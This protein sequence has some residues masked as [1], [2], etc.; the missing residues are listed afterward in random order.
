MFRRL[1][2]YR[3]AMLQLAG[4]A[5]VTLLMPAARAQAALPATSSGPD[6]P[7]S[8]NQP[9]RVAGQ[10]EGDWRMRALSFALLA[11]NPHNLQPWIVDLRQA[12]QVS[13]HY[14]TSRALPMTDP[15]GRQ[16]LIGC[17]CFLELLDMAAREL[18]IKVDTRYFPQ[19]TPSADKLD[20]KPLATLRR[21][22]GTAVADPLFAH[23]LRRRSTKAAYDMTREVS[24]EARATM[25]Q[26]VAGTSRANGLSLSVLRG[27]DDKEKLDAL[28]D[29]IWQAWLIEASTPRTHKESVDLMRIGSA[30]VMANPDGISL[31]S[32]MF[33]RMK[34]AGQISREAMLDPNSPGNRMGQQRYAAM[35]KATP[36]M[37]W[38]TSAD[39]SRQT[40]LDSG[41]A[42]M[43]AA[44]AATGLGLSVH[45][46]SQALQ[47]YPEM[48]SQR[49]Q[50]HRLLQAAEP[51]RVQM[52]CRLGYGP[53]VEPSPRR[54]LQALLRST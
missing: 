41:R 51:S 45:P 32:P 2:V 46:V 34:A 1:T 12:D 13:L 8:A 42:Y 16:L 22:A 54:P 30:E 10:V 43:R 15:V 52:L 36:A 14:D 7:L 28:R 31:G 3:R 35:M 17:G 4:G 40:Q 11:P 20:S 38:L 39:N 37:L 23:V 47:E 26:A 48:A 6:V 21:T 33:D 29:L 18:G 24:A 25:E 44:L 50:A 49:E 9:W 27:P 53:P 19:G 5:A